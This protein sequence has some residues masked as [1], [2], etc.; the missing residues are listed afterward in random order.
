MESPMNSHGPKPR[1]P[2]PATERVTLALEELGD[3]EL[4]EDFAEVTIALV[5]LTEEC[6][7]V[8]ALLRAAGIDPDADLQ[9]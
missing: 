8:K 2:T 5:W 9:H 1:D 6:S 4:F 3:A 7:R